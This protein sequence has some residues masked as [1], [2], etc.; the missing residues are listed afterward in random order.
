[1]AKRPRK[2]RTAAKVVTQAQMRRAVAALEKDGKPFG[3]FHLRPDGSVDVLTENPAPA[4]PPP[5]SKAKRAGQIALEEWEK[6]Y[7]GAPKREEEKP[8]K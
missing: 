3:G 7:G 4:S 1:M 5:Q 8:K 6:E 2:P